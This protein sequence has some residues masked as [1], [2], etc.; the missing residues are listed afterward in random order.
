MVPRSRTVLLTN[1]IACY[2]LQVYIQG[3]TI[4]L[5]TKVFRPTIFIASVIVAIE[6]QHESFL[7][8]K[9][10]GFQCFGHGVRMKAKFVDEFE[11]PRFLVDRSV[12]NDRISQR[13]GRAGGFVQAKLN[14][15]QHATTTMFYCFLDSLVVVAMFFQ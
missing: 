1:F 10:S 15:T 5:A 3:L 7:N 6:Q 9:I 14:A 11:S 4:R 13:C 8:R 12:G 2:F